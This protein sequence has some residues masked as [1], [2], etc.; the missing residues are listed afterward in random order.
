MEVAR[1]NRGAEFAVHSAGGCAWPLRVHP[2]HPPHPVRR[3]WMSP[4]HLP[5]PLESDDDLSKCLQSLGRGCLLCP[6]APAGPL[7]VPLPAQNVGFALHIP[8]PPLPSVH[9]RVHSSHRNR[10]LT[11]P[12]RP[13][14]SLRFRIRIQA[15]G[16][17]PRVCSPTLSNL[18]Q[19]PS[20]HTFPASL[21]SQ[22]SGGARPHRHPPTDSCFF[23][24]ASPCV[25]YCTNRKRAIYPIS[26]ARDAHRRPSQLNKI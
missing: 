17:T 3:S 5:C 8:R 15:T 19:R 16:Q 21:A 9:L 23:L 2:S 6:V 10:N 24:S 14:S 11:W 13:D 7:K 26:H 18:N 1:R 25:P 22:P 4:L 12:D 20:T